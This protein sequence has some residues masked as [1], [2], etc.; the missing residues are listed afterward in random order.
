MSA[1]KGAQT[2]P[3]NI[4]LHDVVSTQGGAKIIPYTVTVLFFMMW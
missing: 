4:F 2:I 3:Y 1:A